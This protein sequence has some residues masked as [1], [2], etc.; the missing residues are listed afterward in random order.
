MIK[1]TTTKKEAEKIAEQ[2]RIDEP[3]YSDDVQISEETEK[4]EDGFGVNMT[5]RW[6]IHNETE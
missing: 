2:M 3:D 1:Y 4:D 6:I 5:G